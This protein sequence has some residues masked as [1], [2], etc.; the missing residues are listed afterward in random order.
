[1]GIIVRTDNKSFRFVNRATIVLK[2]GHVAS[3][4]RIAGYFDRTNANHRALFRPLEY[5]NIQLFTSARNQK[6]ITGTILNNSFT[7]ESE[8]RLATVSGYTQTGILSDTKIHLEQYPIEYNNL[9]LIQIAQRLLAPFGLFVNAV[10]DDGAASEVIDSIKADNS[11][12]ISEFLTN[13]AAQKNLI[14]THD[15]DGDL[16][17]T[18]ANAEAA[19]IATYDESIPATSI[20][21][22]VNGQN[23]HSRITVLQ[24]VDL[25]TDNA[26]ESTIPNRIVPAFRP[27]TQLQNVG[28]D[29]DTEAA[30]RRVRSKELRNIVLTIRTDRWEWLNNGTPQVM[31]PNNIISVISPENYIFQRTKFFVETVKLFLDAKK[32]TAELTCVLPEVFTGEEPKAIFG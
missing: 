29:N 5:N 32:Q 23:V 25:E 11:E 18:K 21:L 3:G 27:T 14:L 10:N 1:M 22:R 16:I 30:A 13:I 31:R 26:A 8:Q 4:F 19:P 20:S 24:E 17:I 28:T 12:P 15:E 6:L 9:S 7:L 2:Y